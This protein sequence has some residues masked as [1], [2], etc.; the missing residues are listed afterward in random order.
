V[1]LDNL[2]FRKLENG[3]TVKYHVSESNDPASG[4]F[5]GEVYCIDLSQV[6]KCVAALIAKH[7][8]DGT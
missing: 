1:I 3:W 4:K 6:Q 7:M 5:G 2:K 8:E